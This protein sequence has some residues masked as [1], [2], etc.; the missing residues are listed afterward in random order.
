MQFLLI[1]IGLA[2]LVITF[3]DFFH[4]TISGQGFG[5]ISGKLNH[6]IDR[7]ILRNRNYFIFKY[8]G[9]IHLLITTLNWLVLVILGTFIIFLSGDNMVLIA[10]TKVPATIIER[11][12]FTCYLLSTLGIG[13]M[14]PGTA[15]SRILTAI[16]SF[17]GFILLTTALTYLISVVN[18]VLQ[19]KQLAAYISTLG[20]NIEKLYEFVVLRNDLSTLTG[21]SN[22]LRKLIIENSNYFNFFPI[23][24]YF[25]TRKKKD[26][27]E[28][29]LAILNEVLLVLRGNFKEG[30]FQREK[31]T[32]IDNVI[33]YYLDLKLLNQK[34]FIYNAEE[35]HELREFWNKHGETY[36]NDPDRD[37][38][39]T[40]ALK[41]AGWNWEDVYSVKKQ[42]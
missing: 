11:F 25:L 7:I 5:I 21:I 28:L 10:Q 16:L 8:S 19:K 23:I 38:A 33:D 32:E 36:E 6:L 37:K 39:M 27:V 14:V 15:L 31:L 3:L 24:D 29:Q 1:G 42:F 40:T 18:A 22:D 4:T 12:Y 41:G 26:S 9:F 20:G 35:L 2:I 30:S 34:R 13:D 17:S